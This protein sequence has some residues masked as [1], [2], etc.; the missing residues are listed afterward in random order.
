MHLFTPM[1]I[2]EVVLRNRIAVSP[3]CQ[4]SSEDGFAN[5][6]HLVHL[7]AR[8]VGGAGLV[9][10]EA[11]AVTPDGRISPQDLGIWSDAHVPN[12]ARITKFIRA[13]GAAAG[14]QLAHAGRKAST[15]R[16][17][18]PSGVAPEEEGGWSRVVAPSP[19]PFSDR[20]LT[21][22]A[23][24]VTEIR[25]VI[26]AFVQATRRSHEAGFQVVEIH[27]AHGYLLHQ[28]LSPLSNFRTDEYGG[29]FE[30]RI[31]LVCEVTEA[32]RAAWPND[33]PLFLRVSASDWAE[34]GWKT[35]DTVRLAKIVQALGVDLIDC[36][37]GGAIPKAEIPVG[38]GY[39]VPFSRAVRAAGV[40]SAAVGLITAPA[41]ADAIIR[42]GDADMVMIARELLRDPHWPLHAARELGYEISWPV[43]YERAKD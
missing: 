31:R 26:D 13:Q 7:G 14:I 28:F 41:Q 43:Q 5:D 18:E 24:D 23:L 29:S 12:L 8:A 6:W 39:Q 20:T 27:G 30:N 19:I 3:M 37:S 21:P 36:S 11:T 38:S 9:M 2:R 1:H 40:P 34:G 22:E 33:L 17:W 16:P 10:A 15:R 35:D 25:S 42:N 4:Y 32:V